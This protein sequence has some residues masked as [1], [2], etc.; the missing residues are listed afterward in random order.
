[1][2]AHDVV[3]I[4][5]VT[6]EE[7]VVVGKAGASK[8]ECGRGTLF[9]AVSGVVVYAMCIPIRTPGDIPRRGQFRIGEFLL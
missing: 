8:L 2:F 6:S 3:D 1:M 5:R 9:Q 7:K 4:G